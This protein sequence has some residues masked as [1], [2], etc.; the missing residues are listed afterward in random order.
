MPTISMTVNG[1]TVSGEAEGRITR[2]TLP[3]PQ[4]WIAEVLR[5]LDTLGI[6]R[7]AD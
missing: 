5:L 2:S 4:G 3:G 7:R 6:D 1:K